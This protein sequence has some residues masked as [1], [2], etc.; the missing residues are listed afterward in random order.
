M[1]VIGIWKSFQQLVVATEKSNALNYV[2]LSFLLL[3]AVTLAKEVPFHL[4]L[5]SAFPLGCGSLFS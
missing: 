2:L 3:T 4:F 1:G 5:Y